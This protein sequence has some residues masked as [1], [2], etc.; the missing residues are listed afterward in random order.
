MKKTWSKRSRDTVPLTV[1]I[2][3]AFAP[4]LTQWLETKPLFF[5]SEKIVLEWWTTIGCSDK[6]W[7]VFIIQYLKWLKRVSV[8]ESRLATLCSL[9]TRR[10]R[11]LYTTAPGTG[12]V[13]KR[14][15][16]WTLELLNRKHFMRIRISAF[17][18]KCICIRNTIGPQFQ[19]HS[20]PCQWLVIT[21]W[22]K[23]FIS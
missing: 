23:Y 9:L 22:N 12:L 8:I 21:R 6:P 19:M 3:P 7:T 14:E 10:Q 1:S 13:R 5:P 4:M 11:R 17:F 15:M 16:L 20:M 18:S 2:L